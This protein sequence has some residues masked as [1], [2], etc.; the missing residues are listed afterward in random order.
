MSRE[1]RARHPRP[2]E[3]RAPGETPGDPRVDRGTAGETPAVHRTASPTRSARG[4]PDRKPRVIRPRSTGPQLPRDPPAV[5]RAEPAR[6]RGVGIQ[7]MGHPGAHRPPWPRALQTLEA[8][9]LAGTLPDSSLGPRRTRPSWSR[10][11]MRRPVAA[12]IASARSSR[13]PGLRLD[14]ARALFRGVLAGIEPPWR[15][16]AAFANA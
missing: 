12:T 9:P 4:P 6:P 7:P 15:P 13:G 11:R 3:P 14:S 8:M 1:F 10:P 16:R 5:H 2:N